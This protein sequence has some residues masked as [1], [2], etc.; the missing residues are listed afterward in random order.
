MTMKNFRAIALSLGVLFGL[1]PLAGLAQEKTEKSE[2][3]EKA[4]KKGG[5]ENGPKASPNYYRGLGD[6]RS[7]ASSAS[8]LWT[9]PGP[10]FY[11][12]ELRSNSGF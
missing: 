5:K 11:M 8:A 12:R 3:V 10:D 1:A 2:K 4:E 7:V 9:S 6:I